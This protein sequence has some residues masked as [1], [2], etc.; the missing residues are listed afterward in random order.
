MFMRIVWGKILPGKWTE[1]ED[2]F[3]T[4]MATRG[5]LQ[6]LREHWLARDQ[7]DPNAGYSITLW[8]SEAD[9]KAFWDSPKRQETMAP[10]EPFYVNQF[11]TTH[12]EVRYDAKR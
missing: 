8:E 9:M 3:K 12:C 5:D 7:A 2:A 4:A 11:T 1:F 10:L 6:G